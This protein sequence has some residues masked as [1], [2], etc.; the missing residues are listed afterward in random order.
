M[1]KIIIF[2]VVCCASAI[3]YTSCSKDEILSPEADNFVK[4]SNY[5]LYSDNSSLL[6][7]QKFNHQLSRNKKGTKF[8]IQDDNLST[9][10]ACIFSEKIS[11]GAEIE[12]NIKS[13]GLNIDSNINIICKVIKTNNNTAWLWSENEKIGIITFIE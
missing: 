8:R 1:K 13:L 12:V 5:G 7:Y 2:I 6:E 3:L 10:F 11:D 4:R 9:Y